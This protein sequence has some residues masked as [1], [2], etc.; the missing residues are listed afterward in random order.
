LLYTITVSNSHGQTKIKG[1]QDIRSCT[2]ER[3]NT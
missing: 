3:V 1:I 2:Y